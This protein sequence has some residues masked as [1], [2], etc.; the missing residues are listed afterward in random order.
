[1]SAK[2]EGDSTTGDEGGAEDKEPVSTDSEAARKE[3]DAQGTSFATPQSQE[4][5]EGKSSLKRKAEDEPE[6]KKKKKGRVHFGSEGGAPNGN[7]PDPPPSKPT[8]QTGS[9]S[10]M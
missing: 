7:R 10:T 1:M 5:Q 9:L 4:S 6:D 2:A 8:G 3:D